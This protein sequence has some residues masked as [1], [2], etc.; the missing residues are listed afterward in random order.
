MLSYSTYNTENK[1]KRQPSIGLKPIQG[2]VTIEQMQNSTPA[3]IEDAENESEE[4]IKKINELLGKQ[5]KISEPLP[6]PPNPIVQKKPD[7]NGSMNPTP[8]KYS[9]VVNEPNYGNYRQVYDQ[10]VSRLE[11]PAP[12]Y[13]KSG[14]SEM[15]RIL[16][17]LNHLTMMME[18]QRA[19]KTAH[20]GEEF[21]LYTMVGV[22]V[23]YIVDSFSRVGKYTR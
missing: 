9:P 16:E 18:E 1:N 6:F 15:D 8:I 19:E 17:R 7:S 23:I 11:R 20:I 13:A 4:R 22:F 21:V 2:N 3:T 10:P 14:S 12:Y 5:N